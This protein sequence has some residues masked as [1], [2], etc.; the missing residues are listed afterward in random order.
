MK[1]SPPLSRCIACYCAWLALL[2]V[3]SVFA[4]R[5]FLNAAPVAGGWVTAAFFLMVVG[6]SC[7]RSCIGKEELKE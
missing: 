7:Q 6:G 1:D 3:A 5:L 4:G 2:C